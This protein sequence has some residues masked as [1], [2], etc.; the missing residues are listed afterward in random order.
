MRLP[1]AVTPTPSLLRLSALA[2][3]LPAVGLTLLD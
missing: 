3:E 2:G 1:L